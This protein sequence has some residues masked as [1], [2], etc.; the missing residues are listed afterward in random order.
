MCQQYR[1]NFGLEK[2][3]PFNRQNE[4]KSLFPWN[5]ECS[6]ITVVRGISTEINVPFLLFHFLPSVL[7]DPPPPWG[8]S[9]PVGWISGFLDSLC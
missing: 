4:L 1:T 8:Y 7:P 5:V 2:H 9:I 3:E 6:R